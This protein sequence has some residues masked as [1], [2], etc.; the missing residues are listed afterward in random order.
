MSKKRIVYISWQ[1]YCSR[2]DNTARELGGKSF[3]IYYKIFGSHY[4]TIAFKYICQIMKSFGVLLREKPDV[5]F[6]MSPPVFAA[7]PV[8]LYC[9]LLNKPFV[10]DAHTG[11][12]VDKMWHKAMF[13]Q[14]FFCRTAVFTIVTNQRLA[15]NVKQWRGNPVII[16]DIPIQ[17]PDPVFPDMEGSAKITLVNTFAADEPLSEFIEAAGQFPDVHFYITGKINSKTKIYL[18]N[19]RENIHFTDFLPDAAY[20]GL[21]LQSDLITVLTTRNHTMQRG[22]YEAIYLGRPVITSNW[23]V[24]KKNFF[25]GA[26]FVDNSVQGIADGINK[27]LN[28]LSNLKKEAQKLKSWKFKNWEKNKKRILTI[29]L[30]DE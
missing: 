27:A 19:K 24:L 13:L 25:Q 5:V 28:N 29:L 9:N 26:V 18:E 21:L 20:H 2:S 7:I 11:A 22:A 6:V 14:R 3:L 1:D 12:F 30:K 4:A 10:V 15:N 8:Y 16:P 17:F 23:P